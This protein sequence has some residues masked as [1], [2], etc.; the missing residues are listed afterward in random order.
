[1]QLTAVSYREKCES[2]L[3]NFRRY[4]RMCFRTD[5]LVALIVHIE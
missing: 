4:A 2:K 3:W 1:M 5:Q